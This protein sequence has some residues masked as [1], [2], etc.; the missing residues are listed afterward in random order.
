MLNAFEVAAGFSAGTLEIL[1]R[2]IYG[3]LI[4]FWAAWVM[5]KQFH[6]LSGQNLTLGEYGANMS[7]L[8]I[9][10]TSLMLVIVV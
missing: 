5:T 10:W 9:L 2:V 6:L 1:F 3:G 8:L 4:T 7:K